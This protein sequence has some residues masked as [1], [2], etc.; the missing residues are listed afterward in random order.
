MFTSKLPLSNEPDPY[1]FKTHPPFLLVGFHREAYTKLEALHSGNG[2]QR[3]EGLRWLK[4]ELWKDARWVTLIATSFHSSAATEVRRWDPSKRERVPIPASKTVQR[5]NKFMGAV[6]QFNKLL[7]ATCMVMGRCKQR[8]HRALFLCW[9]LP[10][11]GVVN[12]RIAFNEL[13]RLRWGDAALKS[14]QEARGIQVV[15]WN[16]W[17][18]KEL[19]KAL[20]ERAVCSP[21]PL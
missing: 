18:Q 14:L 13:V 5:Y 1:I 20:V 7:A 12:V 2:E 9:L 21:P 4:A 8:F 10:A 16:K 3:A 15:G 6:D 19:G 11:V 17:F